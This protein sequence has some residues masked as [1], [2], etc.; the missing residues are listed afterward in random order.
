[1]NRRFFMDSPGAWKKEGAPPSSA[2]TGTWRCR[3]RRDWPGPTSKAPRSA[4]RSS[5]DS[6]KAAAFS[7]GIW[8]KGVGANSITTPGRSV[9]TAA[10]ITRSAR[11]PSG[12]RGIPQGHA[13]EQPGRGQNAEQLQQLRGGVARGPLKCRRPVPEQENAHEQDPGPYRAASENDRPPATSSGAATAMS[14]RCCAMWAANSGFRD[15]RE[16][17]QQRGRDSKQ[18]RRR[19]RLCASTEAWRHRDGGKGV[20][21]MAAK[22]QRLEKSPQMA[23]KWARPSAV[24]FSAFARG[25]AGLHEIEPGGD[26]RLP[27]RPGSR[28]RR[29]SYIAACS[30]PDEAMASG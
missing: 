8:A 12:K 15:A 29:R 26:A 18:S 27:Q 5:G 25:G 7:C 14:R 20:N 21:R 22:N 11:P 13:P 9:A 28:P 16:R 23:R 1:M 3:R 2:Q 19:S 24:D 17:R 30:A 10:V 4:G 6:P